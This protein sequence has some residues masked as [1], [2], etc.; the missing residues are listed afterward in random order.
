[1]A[2]IRR[3]YTYLDQSSFLKLYKALVRPQL[4]YCNQVWSPHLAKHVNSLENVQRRATRCI[5]GMKDLSYPERLVKLKLPTL[6]YR[7]LRGDMIETYKITTQKYDQDIAQNLLTFNN[8]TSR[9]NNLKL[10]K[11]QN[12]T[13]IRKYFFTHRIIDPWN[14]LPQTVV[15]APSVKIFEHRLD[16]HWRNHPLI[17]DHCA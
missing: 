3:A 11:P 2:L 9:N 12:R 17:L 14:Q 4:E 13:N 7:R 10:N 6:A 8:R 16:H 1:M 15:D 5:P